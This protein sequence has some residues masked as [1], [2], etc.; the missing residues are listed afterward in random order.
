MPFGYQTSNG[1]EVTYRTAAAAAV[2]V[3]CCIKITEGNKNR[4]T[5]N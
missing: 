3:C 5:A 2:V 1:K 4:S